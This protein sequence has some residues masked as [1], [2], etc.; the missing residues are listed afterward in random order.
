M[1]SSSSPRAV[2]RMIG[3]SR[4]VRVAADAAADLD[5]RDIGQHPVEQT[6]SGLRSST[7]SKAS[8]PSRRDIFWKP[9]FQ[10][11]GE[12]LDQRRS[13]S[14]IRTWG[15]RLLT[16]TSIGAIGRVRRRDAGLIGFRAVPVERDAFDLIVDQFGDV[17]CQ[18]ADALDIAATKSRWVQAVMLRASSI[19]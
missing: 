16:M 10:I 19:M 7:A 6:M 15:C 11:V 9:P 18:I 3:R 5:A 12:Q 17:G 4:S 8:S 14:T 13:S 1:R 2:S